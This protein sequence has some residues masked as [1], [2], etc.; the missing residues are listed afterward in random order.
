M[1]VTFGVMYN[2]DISAGDPVGSEWRDDA[3]WQFHVP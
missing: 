3:D 1:S 2:Y